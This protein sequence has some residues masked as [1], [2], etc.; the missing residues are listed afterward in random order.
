[1]ATFMVS[2]ADTGPGIAEAISRRSSRNSSR[3][4]A[5]A[6]EKRAAP[7][8]ASRLLSGSSSCMADASG[9]NSSPGQGSTFRFTLPV[10]VERQVEVR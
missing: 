4:R 9:S 8:L 2:V 1:M 6:P 5:P 3:P 10:R 7:D